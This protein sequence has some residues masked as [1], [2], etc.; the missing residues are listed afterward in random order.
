MTGILTTPECLQSGYMKIV[1]TD[2]LVSRLKLRKIPKSLAKKVYREKEAE[3]YDTIK[4]HYLV[5][6]RQELFGKIRLLV[7]VFDKFEDRIELITLYPTDG[8]EVG[9]RI[10][11]GR[12]VYEKV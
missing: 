11:A 10:K 2:H 4:H 1:F 5:L 7:V 9:N 6:S 8:Q 12:W 3:F